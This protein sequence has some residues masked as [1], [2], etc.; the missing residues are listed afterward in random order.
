VAGDFVV[1]TDNNQPSDGARATIMFLAAL[2]WDCQ[3]RVAPIPMR[4]AIKKPVRVRSIRLPIDG[5]SLAI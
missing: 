3:A 1:E 4:T 5:R 2:P